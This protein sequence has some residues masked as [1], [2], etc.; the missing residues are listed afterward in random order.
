MQRIRYVQ[1]DPYLWES[2]DI[3]SCLEYWHEIKENLFAPK[4]K[5]FQWEKIS[6]TIIPYFIV[7]DIRH[8][9]YSMKYRFFGTAH[10]RSYDIDLTGKSP[11]DINPSIIGESI[12]DQYTSV[13][14]ERK[15]ALFFHAIQ[16][17][18]G[19]KD[20]VEISEVTLRIPFSNDGT[21][22]TNILS[23]VDLRDDEMRTRNQ[24]SYNKANELK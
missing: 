7:V 22:V 20:A 3:K 15:P 9:P 24:I 21:N 4:W 10:V 16:E 5:E 18:N 1:Y 19:S 23:F 14:K 13:A 17:S 8:T 12:F 11:L 2:D 6:T